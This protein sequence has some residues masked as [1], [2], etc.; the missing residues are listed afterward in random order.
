MCD[1]SGG[2][3]CQ[4]E[5]RVLTTGHLQAAIKEDIGGVCLTVAGLGKVLSRRDDWVV[6]NVDRK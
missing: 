2:K 5:A 1:Y 6:L 3:D 4:M